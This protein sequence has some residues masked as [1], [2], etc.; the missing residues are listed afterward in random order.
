MTTTNI[1]D[2]VLLTVSI[3]LNAR[4]EDGNHVREYVEMCLGAGFED[5]EDTASELRELSEAVDN[6]NLYGWMM[7]RRM[8]T[9]LELGELRAETLE[10]TTARFI[11][12][13][14][15]SSQKGEK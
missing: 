10:E 6:D 7:Q 11:E 9:S 12:E 2:L 15:A 4:D 8:N 1:N 5:A 14:S 3:S 13:N